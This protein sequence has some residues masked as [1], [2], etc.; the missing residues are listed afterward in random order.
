[1]VFRWYDF[2]L[3]HRLD[4]CGVSLVHDASDMA[5][6]VFNVGDSFP[7]IEAVKERIE[8]Y[9]EQIHVP[10]SISDGRTI[11]SANSSKRMSKSISE[12]KAKLLHY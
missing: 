2:N 4:V 12:E 3:T 7:S 9:S 5:E 10:L 1:M 6:I 8:L 11:Q